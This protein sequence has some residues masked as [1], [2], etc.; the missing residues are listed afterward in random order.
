MTL[1]DRLKKYIKHNFSK[2]EFSDYKTDDNQIVTGEVEV[3]KQLLDLESMTPLDGELVIDGKKI[4]VEKGVVKSVEDITPME[5]DAMEKEQ[6]SMVDAEVE[7]CGECSEGEDCDCETEDESVEVPVEESMEMPLEDGHMKE[8]MDTI[9]TLKSEIDS[10]KSEIE[11]L[12]ADKMKMSSEM[13]ELANKPVQEVFKS[14]EP[15]KSKMNSKDSLVNSLREMRK[16][17]Q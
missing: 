5:E 1:L 6:E 3:G 8:M 13:E 9:D 4:V 2:Q 14:V 16:S 7:V 17:I 10:L 12:K 11:T 15:I